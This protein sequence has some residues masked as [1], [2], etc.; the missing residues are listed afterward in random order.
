MLCDS[1]T[2]GLGGT[3]SASAAL[4]DSRRSTGKASGTLILSCHRALVQKPLRAVRE[5]E[6]IVPAQARLNV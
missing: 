3:G 5:K 6:S 1:L 2:F 4:P